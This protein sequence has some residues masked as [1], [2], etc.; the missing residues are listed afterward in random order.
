MKLRAPYPSGSRRN[1]ALTLF[2]LSGALPGL[3][4]VARAQ[5][6]PTQTA[7]KSPSSISRSIQLAKAAQSSQPFPIART[8]MAQDGGAAQPAPAG[9]APGTVTV[10]G[11]IDVFYGL[12]FNHSTTNPQNTGRSF[13]Q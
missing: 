8:V 7:P 11:L 9:P 1:R 13:D 10:T 4:A 3:H 6:V 12:S 5:N 2:A